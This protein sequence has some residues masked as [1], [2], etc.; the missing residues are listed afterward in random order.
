VA[1]FDR[2]LSSILV[3]HGVLAEGAREEAVAASEK[4]QKS[5]TEYLVAH[6]VAE[7]DIIG[8]VSMETNLPPIDL[9]KVEADPEAL[10]L[11]SESI[12]KQ[13]QVLPVAKI[14]STLTIAV[15]N[16]MDVVRQDDINIHTGCDLLPVVSTDVAIRKAIA[17]AYNGGV[18]SS[19]AEMQDLVSEMS[20]DDLEL[21]QEGDEKVDVATEAEEAESAPVVRLVKLIIMEGVKSGASD[22]HIEPYEKKTRVRYRIDGAC[23]E[24][25][26]PPRHYHNHIV[27]RIKIMSNMD[28]AKRREPQ[29]GKFKMRFQDREIDFRVSVLPIVHGEKVVMRI[30]DTSASGRDL[31]KLG[32]EEKALK[33]FATAIQSANGMVLVTGPTGSGKS[34]TLYSAIRK[35]VSVEDNITTVEDPVEYTMEGINQVQVNA[36]AHLEFA[37]A[38]RSILRQDPDTVLIGEIR[39][40]ETAEIAVKAA[41][42]GHL[43]FSTL[44]TND[45]PGTIT[46]LV[47]MNIEPFLVASCVILV[48][49][50]RLVRRLCKSCTKGYNATEEQLREWGLTEEEIAT[51]PQLYAPAGCGRCTNGY[52][53]RLPLLETLP[54]NEALREI[55]VKGGSAVELKRKGLEQ[56]MLT[57][58][59]VGVLNAIKGTTSIEEVLSSTMPDR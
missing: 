42:T 47:D 39:D 30:L 15:A 52:S 48:S 55:I 54:M 11:M 21:A 51:N 37:D 2:K 56:G 12:A 16:P 8:A 22:I 36:R 23:V 40:L 7:S 33:D 34:T 26:S 1:R 58:R 46:R 41:L 50:Q 32:F 5:L 9:E 35:I 24:Q 19:A 4:E 18:E 43:V 3:K 20:M 25:P 28:I 14:G 38:L 17:K 49:A 44:H 31:E 29:D 45:A 53:G 13:Y 57:L 59:R 27:S 10:E 6:D